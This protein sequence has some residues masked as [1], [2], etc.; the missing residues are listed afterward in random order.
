METWFLSVVV[1]LGLPRPLGAGTPTHNSTYS[2]TG[3]P[4]SEATAEFRST[5]N[6]AP[7]SSSPSSS[8]S[9]SPSQRNVLLTHTAGTRAASSGKSVQTLYSTVFRSELSIN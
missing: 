1:L 9:L 2:V 6:S 3:Y 5:E 7:S 4:Y 8:E